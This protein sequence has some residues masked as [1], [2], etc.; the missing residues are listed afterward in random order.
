MEN[1]YFESLIRIKYINA[2]EKHTCGICSNDI[3]NSD[4]VFYNYFKSFDVDPGPCRCVD[5]F[6]MK[7]EIVDITINNN[8]LFHPMVKK[9]SYMDVVYCK[10]KR[11]RY[12]NTKSANKNI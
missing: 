11:K 3:N 9:A 4:Y 5:C 1:K 8:Y 10:Y 12:T 2:D 6:S 7:W